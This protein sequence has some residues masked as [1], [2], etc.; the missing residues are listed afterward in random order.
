MPNRNRRRRNSD[1]PNVIIASPISSPV[2]SPVA[3]PISSTITTVES[4]TLGEHSE[5]II[6]R[7]KS[8]NKSYKQI[9]DRFMNYNKKI[10]QI[11]LLK[12]REVEKLN[13]QLSSNKVAIKLYQDKIKELM[14]KIEN[15]KKT[16]S[17]CLS[18]ILIIRDGISYKDD[19]DD[20]TKI[21]KKLMNLIIEDLQELQF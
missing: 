6:Q 8:S 7:L 20:M 18:G 4:V 17:E 14:G 2:V 12:A 13:K 9:N 15:Y 16:I 21:Y 3:S 10:K 1:Y 11:L 19:N 5:R